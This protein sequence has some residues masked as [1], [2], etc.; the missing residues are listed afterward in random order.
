[1]SKLNFRRVVVATK[2]AA[3][4]LA[5]VFAMGSALAAQIIYQAVLSGPNEAPP[6]ASPGTGSAKLTID[7]TANTMRVQ[8]TFSGLSGITTASHVHCCTAVARVATAGVATQTP[9]FAGFPLGVT[10][11]TYDLTF[12][13]TL[14]SSFNAAFV[15]ANGATPATAFAT[16]LNGMALG[17]AY[18]NVHSNMFPGGEIRG[19]L[20][21]VPTLDIDNSFT[22]TRYH[23]LTDGL[24]A[25]RYMQGLTGAAL[26]AG[27]NVTG[28]AR[29]NPADIKTYLD[30]YRLSYDIDN[31]SNVDAATDGLLILRYLLGLRGNAL[32]QNAVAVGAPRNTAVDIEAYLGQLTP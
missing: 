18:F 28:A 27:L 25:I 24:L 10:S 31:D 4:T 16:L 26:T 32:I 20:E 13:M 2:V 21:R 29:N 17:G 8:A 3:I 30:S 7:T 15:A 23:A 12:D 14:N 11:G 9:S 22:V 19:F 5:S 1:M 6:N